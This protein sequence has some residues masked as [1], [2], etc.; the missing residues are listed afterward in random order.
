MK[1][2]NFGTGIHAREVKGVQKLKTLPGSWVAYTNVDLIISAHK[3]REIDV[4]MIT[5]DRI[6]LIDLKDWHGKIE[7]KN[8]RWWQNGRDLSKS[9]V[10]KIVENVRNAL[11]LVKSHFKKYSKMSHTPIPTIQGFVVLTGHSDISG[12]AEAEK[13]RVFFAEWLCENGVSWYSSGD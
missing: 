5:P 10:S 7:S 3:S 1:I 6:L 2:I 9:P 8:G 4:I 11:P 12:I 13:K